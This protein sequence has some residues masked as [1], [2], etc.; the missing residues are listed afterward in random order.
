MAKPGPRKWAERRHAQSTFTV[1]RPDHCSTAWSARRTLLAAFVMVA[2]CLNGAANA[3]D[4]TTRRRG[5]LAQLRRVLP[6]SKPWEEWLDKTGELPPD[7]DSLPS[8]PD[9]PDPLTRNEALPDQTAITDPADW[10]ARR[11][12]IKQLFHKWMLGTVPP[13]PDAV[14]AEQQGERREKGI[15][16][17]DVELRFGPGRKAR[18][19]MELWVPAGDGPFPVLLAPYDHRYWATYVVKRGYIA[20][21]YAGSDARDDTD[22][23]LDAYPNHDWSR[24]TRRAW[25]AGR[26]IDHLS[27]WPQVKAGQFAITGHSRNGKQALIA[28]ALDPRIAVVVP[29]GSG[30]CGA[31]PTRYYS[32][33]TLGEGIENITRI[34]PEWFHPRLRFFVGREHRLPI[35]M[36]LLVALSA[37]RPC[38]LGAGLNDGTEDIWALQQSYLSARRVYRLLG[39]EDALRIQWRPGPHEFP[40]DIIEGYLDWCDH[41]F[42]RGK[43]DF[44]ERFIHP[45]DWQAW[46]AR[47][48]RPFNLDD[49][50][51]RG[52]TDALVLSDD[53]LV[54]DEA[55]LHRHKR[56]VRAAVTDMLGE[57]S[58]RAAQSAPATGEELDR[59]AKLLGR[60]SAGKGLHRECVVFGDSLNADVYMP[61][62]TRKSGKK[63]PAILWLHPHCTSW[64]YRGV[65][66]RS[67]YRELARAG[68][69]VFC[70]DH[71]GHGQRVEQA[72][73][74]Y[75]H[76]ADWSLLGRMVHDARAAL[77]R[78]QTLEYVNTERIYVVG[79]GLGAMVGLHLGAV[80]D[81]PAGFA[82]LCIPQPFRLDTPDKGTGGIRRW[83][84]LRML[85]PRLGH[86]VGHE[87]RIP[88][89]VPDLLAAIAPRPVCIIS[90]KLDRQARLT[91]VGQAVNTARKAYKLR[92][93]PNALTQIAP[94]DYNRLSPRNRQVLLDWLLVQ[95]SG[96]AD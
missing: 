3:D 71:I 17:R 85:V 83:A 63:L 45:W 8:I 52:A 9:L 64:G 2:C 23:F 91:D 10:P 49:Y 94:E 14:H 80:D 93:A 66:T 33:H 74:F 16:V 27:T 36:N 56:H 79:Y 41:H 67:P 81:R 39:A 53:T 19:R 5:Y 88:Y 68:H 48:K 57:P 11:K 90:P 21:Y 18:M 34:F 4:A 87:Q 46:Q 25:G 84:Q 22:T 12:E 51:Q 77:D 76:H 54:T 86:F 13:A 89:D 70:C 82:L 24:L 72:E 31:N 30:A 58:D 95:T 32:D 55:G 35:D 20:C 47:T 73:R 92:S 28:A 6:E 96:R 37:P 61:E 60:G 78:M 69:A 65:Y 44:P 38:M 26:C 43:H 50:A 15:T 42:D 62:D 40:V 75:E 59:I 29:T 1:R 7:F